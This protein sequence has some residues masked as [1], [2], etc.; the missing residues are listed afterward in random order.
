MYCRL[1]VSSQGGEAIL[2]T[3]LAKSSSPRLSVSIEACPHEAV[4]VG[5]RCD[6]MWCAAVCYGGCDGA[7]AS[8]HC[9]RNPAYSV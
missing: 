9:L 3:W 7:P 1:F 4:P 6:A 2:A 5:V 8:L